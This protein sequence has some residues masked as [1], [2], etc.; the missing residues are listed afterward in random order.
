MTNTELQEEYRYRVAE[1]LAIL[2]G[3]GNPTPEQL[4]MATEEA[5]MACKELSK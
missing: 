4:Q 2:V 1:R 5:E 3:N